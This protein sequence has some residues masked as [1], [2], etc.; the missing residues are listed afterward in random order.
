MFAGGSRKL[1]SKNPIQI[2]VIKGFC[3]GLGS[4]LIAFF[5]GERTENFYLVL[6]AMILGFVAYGLSI[7]FYVYAQRYLGAAKTSAYYAVTPFIGAA[8]SFLIFRTLPT[9]MFLAAL[10]L[11]LFGVYFTSTEKKENSRIKGGHFSFGKTRRKIP[12]P[13]KAGGHFSFRKTR[14]NDEEGKKGL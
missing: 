4:L 5:K 14:R 7:L 10:V 3:S 12:L 6:C 8:L 9:G 2:V 13:A 11:M 1:S